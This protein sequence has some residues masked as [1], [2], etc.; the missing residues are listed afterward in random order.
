[1][2]V[3]HSIS[4]KAVTCEFDDSVFMQRVKDYLGHKVTVFG[5]LHKNIKGDT[6]R[7]SMERIALSEDLRKAVTAEEW[8]EPEFAH[9]PST[10]DYLRRIRGG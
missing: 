6:L 8:R 2:L 9:L 3:Y 7:V 10:A 5:T 4:K 1:V